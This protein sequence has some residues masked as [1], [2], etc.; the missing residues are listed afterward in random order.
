MDAYLHDLAQ[1]RDAVFPP[2]AMLAKKPLNLQQ[3]RMQHEQMAMS[4]MEQRLMME[5]RMAEEQHHHDAHGH[6]DYSA[7]DAAGGM[8]QNATDA[9]GIPATGL[10]YNSQGIEFIGAQLTYGT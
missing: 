10:T 3:K 1:D 6:G 2:D 9:G 7:G 5:R 4:E 8:N